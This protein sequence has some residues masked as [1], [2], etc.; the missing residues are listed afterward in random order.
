MTENDSRPVGFLGKLRNMRVLT[1]I[2]IIGLLALTIGG[3][4]ILFL[5][6]VA[7]SSK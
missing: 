6:E 2:L 5:I 7:N 1:W 4:T 3:S